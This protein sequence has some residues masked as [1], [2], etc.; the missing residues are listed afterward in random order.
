VECVGLMRAMGLR[1]G[2]TLHEFIESGND[3]MAKA[4]LKNYN[5]TNCM[6]DEIKGLDKFGFDGGL[7]QMEIGFS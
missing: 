2:M 5:Q 6:I 1:V 3:Q 7:N 4:H